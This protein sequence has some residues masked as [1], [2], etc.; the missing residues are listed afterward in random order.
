MIVD[1]YGQ[2]ATYTHRFNRSA[3]NT[4]LDRPWMPTRLEDIDKLITPVDRRTLLAVSRSLIENYGPARSIARQI[5]MFS[6][7][8][9]WIPSMETGDEPTKN[10]AEVVIREGFCTRVDL[11][12]RDFSTLLYHLAHLLIRDGEYFVLLSEWQTGWP[13][14]QVIPSHRIG[15]RD[16]GDM[17]ESG[18]YVGL[19][20]N[21]GVV[22][23][24]AGTPVAYRFLADDPNE[25]FEISARS[26]I[27]RFDS[28]YPEA[29]R[30]YPAISHGLN[31]GR[32]ALQAHEWERLK[33]LAVSAHTLI[34]HTETGVPD[35]DTRNHFDSNGNALANG[36][37]G[38]ISTGTL[39]G[40]IYKTVRAGTGYKLEAMEHKTPGE[41]FESF[42]DRLI[43]KMATGVPWPLSWIW[44]GHKAQGGTAERRDIMQARRTI[45]D[46]QSMIEPTAKRI[47]G[48]AYQKL[49]KLNRVNA[50]ADWWRWSFTKPAKPTI[51]D[52]RV[53]KATLEMWRA[54]LI[55]DED[56]LAEMGKDHD[57][58]FRQRFTNA[59]NKELMFMETQE[60]KGVTLDPRIKGMFTP[61]DTGE[62]KDEDSGND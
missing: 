40:G 48:Y 35:D 21:D 55:N 19:R 4:G 5:P 12:G 9:A 47:L 38:E 7:G 6:V 14:V 3:T 2:P 20:I 25:D 24:K 42:N 53:S 30:G 27:H 36:T 62:Q 51:D 61:N 60:S 26:L 57:D 45:E 10:K 16:N 52:G 34:E 58:H 8:N 44:D 54:G 43:H 37:A 56:V 13:A 31:D 32:D 22:F 29:I 1:Q 18:P 15:Q 28:D 39:F 49:R 33:M 11:Q 41:H 59:A 50:S 17:V 23:N 46:M